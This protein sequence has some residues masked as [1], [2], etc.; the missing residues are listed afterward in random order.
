MSGSPHGAINNEGLSRFRDG[1]QTGNQN[2]NY[3]ELTNLGS[4]STNI[5]YNKQ[6]PNGFNNRQDESKGKFITFNHSSDAQNNE[7]YSKF[8]SNNDLHQSGHNNAQIQSNSILPNVA[9][10]IN[11]QRITSQQDASKGQTQILGD[12]AANKDNE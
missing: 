12:G 10:S 7:Q 2:K 9:K 1:N 4:S 3:R 5:Q 8:K 11:L 6:Q